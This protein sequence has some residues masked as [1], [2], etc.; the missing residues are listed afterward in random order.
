MGV[1]R[2]NDNAEPAT[3]AEIRRSSEQRIHGMDLLSSSVPTD[4]ES[5]VCHDIWS[6]QRHL[7]QRPQSSL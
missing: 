5:N 4:V 3:L 1:G 2:F 7:C 6:S